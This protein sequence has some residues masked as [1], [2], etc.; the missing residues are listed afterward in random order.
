MTTVIKTENELRE[1]V[2]KLARETGKNY[3]TIPSILRSKN[4]NVEIPDPWLRESFEQW[5]NDTVGDIDQFRNTSYLCCTIY[6]L[7]LHLENM[8]NNLLETLGI[9]NLATHRACR[10]FGTKVVHQITTLDVLDAIDKANRNRP[11]GTRLNEG[12]VNTITFKIRE[13]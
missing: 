7:Q 4:V 6:E 9:G 2:T 10:N 8:N 3:V 11:R 1:C 5:C 13:F 12:Q